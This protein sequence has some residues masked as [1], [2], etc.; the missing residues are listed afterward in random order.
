MSPL[1]AWRAAQHEDTRTV[2]DAQLEAFLAGCDAREV[3]LDRASHASP[4]EVRM[5]GRTLGRT[6]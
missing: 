4:I 3:A 5:I 2:S 6:A 1:E